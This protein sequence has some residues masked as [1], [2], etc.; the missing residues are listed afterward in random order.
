[1]KR[2]DSVT[3]LNKEGSAEQ[4]ESMGISRSSVTLKNN[5][6]EQIK[7]F[8]HNKQKCGFKK[9]IAVPEKVRDEWEIKGLG[10][11]LISGVGAV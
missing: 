3:Q 8:P 9:S 10:R 2:D 11:V 4:C 7:Y 5:S 1:M 6:R